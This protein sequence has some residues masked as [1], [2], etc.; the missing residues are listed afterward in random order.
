M[1]RIATILA[2]FSVITTGLACHHTAGICDCSP[3]TPPCLKYGLF[4]PEHPP[5]ADSVQPVPAQAPGKAAALPQNV[6]VQTDLI[7]VPGGSG[8]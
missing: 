5:V 4:A 8:M 6:P 1:R 2:G 7:L 3:I